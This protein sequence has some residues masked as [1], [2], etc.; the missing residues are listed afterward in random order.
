MAIVIPTLVA[1]EALDA[2][3]SSLQAQTVTDFEIIVVA[4]GPLNR[5]LP[6][7][8][9][10]IRNAENGGYGKAINQGIEAS[11]SDWVLALNDD[12]IAAPSFVEKLL[13]AGE[14]RRKIGMVAPQI[15]KYPEGTIDS[16]GLR[17]APDGS[18]KQAK[19]GRGA[20]EKG[21]PVP[22]LL[23]SGCAAFYRRVMLDEVGG[24]EEDFFLYCEETDL[25]L[26]ARWK[27]W[28]CVF[29]PEAVVDHRYSH[30]ASTSL[31]AY[32]VE[33][34]RIAVVVR[35]FPLRMMLAAPVHAFVRYFWHWYYK[36]QGKGLAAKYE[37]TESIGRVL[38]RAWWDGLKRLPRDWRRRKKIQH[39]GRMTAQGFARLLAK[40]RIS[41]REVASQ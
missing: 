21:R 22:A 26:R 12:T 33:R 14:S 31:K 29:A 7:G 19:H 32:Y 2:C 20:I 27:G 1:D 18:S 24:F 38:L 41:G 39:A 25:G 9:R 17:V 3:L 5:E 36:R 37:G 30:S 23:P 35:N 6:E 8:V 28:E 16:A 4:N 15:R 13:E 10:V 40:H 11:S 34:N